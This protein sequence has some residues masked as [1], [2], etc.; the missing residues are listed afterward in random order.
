MARNKKSVTLRMESPEGSKLF[1]ELVKRSDIVLHNYTR[2]TLLPQRSDT[3]ASK[4]STPRSH[5]GGGF[6]YE[7]QWTRCEEALL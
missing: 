2:A 3:T 7:A 1:R 5:C 6:R 4:R